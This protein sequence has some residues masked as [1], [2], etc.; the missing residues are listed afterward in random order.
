MKR[1]FSSSLGHFQHR[2]IGPDEN[3][4]KQ[5]LTYLG[6]SSLEDLVNKIVP[7]QILGQKEEL[8][9]LPKVALTEHDALQEITALGKMNQVLTSFIGMGYYGTKTPP[10]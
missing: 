8:N 6:L 1:F 5:M 9:G 4:Q 2:H 10:V 3:A 7:K